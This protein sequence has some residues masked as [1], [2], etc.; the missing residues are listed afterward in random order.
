MNYNKNWFKKSKS[1]SEIHCDTEGHSVKLLLFN[2][3]VLSSMNTGT[4]MKSKC[5]N[6]V[7]PMGFL[8]SRSIGHRNPLLITI[9][10]QTHFGGRYQIAVA[11]LFITP[12][13]S[14]SYVVLCHAK[15]QGNG[16]RFS[17][18]PLVSP[19]AMG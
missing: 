15:F 13:Q 18:P 14:G 6:Q 10:F 9:R 4:D 2:S 12:D 19:M 17:I 3:S 8:Y 7:S 1:P 16:C 5:T 11:W